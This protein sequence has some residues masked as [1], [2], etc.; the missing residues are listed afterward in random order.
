MTVTDQKPVYELGGDGAV[1]VEN[2]VEVDGRRRDLRAK[3]VQHVGQ[4]LL[5]GQRN[6][7]NH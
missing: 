5:A 2:V 6:P 3:L 4:V 7:V 1:E